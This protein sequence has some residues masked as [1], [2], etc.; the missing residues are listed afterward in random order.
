MLPPALH[1]E[2][3]VEPSPCSPVT[4]LGEKCVVAVALRRT[5]R[6]IVPLVSIWS[7]MPSPVRPRNTR[8]GDDE[9]EV[10]PYVPLTEMSGK[11]TPSVTS[12]SPMWSDVL[13]S[14]FSVLA[15]GALVPAFTT[16]PHSV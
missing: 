13:D 6:L 15:T 10:D 7:G 14:P 8:S 3:V 9:P 2:R 5:L 4:V 1:P 11:P 12:L 16:C